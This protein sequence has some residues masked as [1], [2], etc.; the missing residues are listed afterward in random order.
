V[1]KKFEDG[2]SAGTIKKS[3]I[4]AELGKQISD[5]RGMSGSSD[6]VLKGITGWRVDEVDFLKQYAKD[7]V[8]SNTT[9]D[10][11]ELKRDKNEILSDMAALKTPEADHIAANI[12]FRTGLH[13]FF[14]SNR[15]VKPPEKYEPI[16]MD[17]YSSSRSLTSIV[18]VHIGAMRTKTDKAR[19]KY[20]DEYKNKATIDFTGAWKQG[21]DPNKLTF[22]DADK[23]KDIVKTTLQTAPDDEAKSVASKIAQSHDKSNHGSFTTK[24]HGVYRVKRIASEE[25]FQKINQDIN[26]TGFYYHGTSFDTAQ[27]ILGQTGGFKVFNAASGNIKAGSMLGYGIY[28]ARE[29]SK[30]MQY[31]GNGFRNGSRGVLFVCKASLGKV[32]QSSAR[33][34]HANQP[35]M[36]RKDTDT[37]FMDRP[38]V[39]N[40][41]WAVKRAEQAVPRLWVDAERVQK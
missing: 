4:I 34:F 24:V 36:D 31:V 21:A 8:N 29:S 10:S 26:N 39:I 30:S 11:D 27:K 19:Q 14:D 28:L 12:V 41:E 20:L 3:E 25:K 33:G 15:S 1:Y 22:P 9:L 38:H 23:I 6:T 2:I 13:D 17:D 7:A 18:K 5:I 16:S 35:I 32:V 40:P 37:V